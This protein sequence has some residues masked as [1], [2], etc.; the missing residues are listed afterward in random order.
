MSV[1]LNDPDGNAGLEQRLRSMYSTIVPLLDEDS[2]PGSAGTGITF[3]SNR[4]RPH[5]RGRVGVAAVVLLVIGVVAVQRISVDNRPQHAVDSSLP[6]IESTMPEPVATPAQLVTVGDEFSEALSDVLADRG[7]TIDE[8]IIPSSGLSRPDFFNWSNTLP[9]LLDELPV[10]VPVVVAF[11][12]N[13]FQGLKAPDG[14][15][16]AEPDDPEWGEQYANRVREFMSELTD[17]GHPVIW[18]GVNQPGGRDLPQPGSDSFVDGMATIR[19]LTM[20]VAA[21]VPDVT[22]IDTWTLLSLPDGSPDPDSQVADQYHLTP[23][24]AAQIAETVSAALLDSAPPTGPAPTS[25]TPVAT[26]DAPV[27]EPSAVPSSRRL[28][29][30]EVPDWFGTFTMHTQ[31]VDAVLGT[32]GTVTYTL[33][34][35]PSSFC[36]RTDSGSGCSFTVD[37]SNMFDQ[38]QTLPYIGMSN[39]VDGPWSLRVLAPLDVQLRLISNST[40]P[41]ELQSFT[42]QPYADVALWACESTSSAPTS[43]TIEGVRGDDTIVFDPSAW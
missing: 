33:E 34:T 43:Y 21:S 24:G 35:T 32:T 30:D 3:A 15:S 4:P 39:G 5:G 18:I 13:D 23:T 8:R 28:T 42:L 12:G 10:G 20:E 7:W 27:T 37:G 19:Q 14:S 2:E 41:C 40:P 1:D 26:T 6:A 16:V 25:S 9:A 38:P 31:T 11:G 29:R 17:A 22:Y 36:I